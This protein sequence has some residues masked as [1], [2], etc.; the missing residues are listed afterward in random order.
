MEKESN[1][2]SFCDRKLKSD[3]LSSI[4]DKTV[5]PIG[6]LIQNQQTMNIL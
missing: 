3:K 6:D 1:T 4:Y 2:Y 5:A